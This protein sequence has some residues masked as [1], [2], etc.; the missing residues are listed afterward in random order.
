MKTSQPVSVEPPLAMGTHSIPSDLDRMAPTQECFDTDRVVRMLEKVTELTSWSRQEIVYII[1]YTWEK[2]LEP[3]EVL[4]RR[5]D[6]ANH[7]FCL[8]QGRVRVL[9]DQVHDVSIGCVGQE[10]ALGIKSYLADIV[11][12]DKTI[13][14]VLPGHVFQKSTDSPRGE[15]LHHSLLSHYTAQK[16][17]IEVPTPP[18]ADRSGTIRSM[19]V[20]GWLL[21]LLLPAAIVWFCEGYG[22]NWHQRH[23]LGVLSVCLLMWA[24]NLVPQYAAALIA[25]LGCLLLDVA[26]TSVILSGF[27][28]DGFFMALSIYGMGSVLIR[29]GLATRLVLN[30]LHISPQTPFWYNVT[31]LLTGVL[32]TPCLPSANARIGVMTPLL[33]EASRALGYKDG[34]REAT[35]LMLSM[36]MG[37][38]LF[39]PI[40][41]TSKSLNFVVYTLLPQQVSEAFQWLKWTLASSVAGGVMLVLYVLISSFIFRGGAKPRLSRK[42]LEAQLAFL[43]PMDFEEWI[44]LSS[45]I[46]FIGAIMTYS[47]HKI[48]LSWITL[49]MFCAYLISGTLNQ[50][51]LRESIEW[52]ILLLIG[53]FIGLEDAFSYTGISD[54]LAHNLASV[55]AYMLSNFEVF[56]VMMIVAIGMIRLLLPITTAGVFMA[57]IFLPIAKLNGINPWVVGFV[58]LMLSECWL[59]PLQCSYFLTF[60]AVSDSK[61][62]HDRELFLRLNLV[63]VAIRIIAL[64]ASLPFF[65]YLGLL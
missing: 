35:R 38:S 45:L 9:A 2:S 48:S 39:A 10:A 15:T 19:K 20:M 18:A 64:F 17:E 14:L 65:R 3:G 37:C 5:G 25:G 27:A 11:A 36:F 13:V 47:I 22:F 31:T 30:I 57:S 16:V 33:T 44:A 21:T 8:L 55:T 52:N 32:M 28:S 1:P 4:C 7:T 34:S 51:H 42:R 58:I 23:L 60:E 46:L 6:P 63:T 26:P 62:V 49:G 50:Q 53:F 59:L 29:S 54:M 56:I 12:V 40:F 43:G 24:F 61:P 41:L